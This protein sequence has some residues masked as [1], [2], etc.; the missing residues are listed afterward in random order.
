MKIALILICLAGQETV[1]AHTGS[2]LSLSFSPDGKLLA[3]GARD[4]R[5][6]IHD[7]KTR[8][9]VFESAVHG[10]DVYAVSFSPD[11]KTLATGGADKVV[12]LW[13]TSTWKVIRSFEG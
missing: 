13:D 7:V 9:L 8:A 2:V 3:S 10:A 4:D 1:K 6:L 12:R 11:G 5:I